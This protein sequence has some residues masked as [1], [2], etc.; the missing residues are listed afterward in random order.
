M[1]YKIYPLHTLGSYQFVIILSLYQG[2][3]LLSRH[4]Q[5]TSWEAQG[6]HIEKGETPLEAAKR[7]LY[8]ESGAVDYQIVPAFDYCVE[9]EA[10]EASGM[11]FFAEI[12]A[13]DALPESE[14]KEV[15]CF[16]QLPKELTYPDITPVLFAHA[17]RR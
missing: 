4:K 12:N 2:K 14:M 8:E 9:D 17:G 3:L 7:E 15:A 6:G 1:N 5:R 16:E 11:V 13:L 10:S